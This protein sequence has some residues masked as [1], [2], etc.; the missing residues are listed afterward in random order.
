MIIFF[1]LF[2]KPEKTM[3]QHRRTLAEYIFEQPELS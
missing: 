2:P 3:V 1:I